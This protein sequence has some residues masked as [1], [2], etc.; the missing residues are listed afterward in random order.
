MTRCLVRTS[1]TKL[2]RQQVQYS[3]LWSHASALQAP[4]HSMQTCLLEGNTPKSDCIRH[5]VPRF[6]A[7]PLSKPTYA[8][9]K[10]PVSTSGA[11]RACASHIGISKQN[12][13]HCNNF[14]CSRYGQGA[15]Q[16][17]KVLTILSKAKGACTIPGILCNHRHCYWRLISYIIL[18]T[19]KFSLYQILAPLV[20]RPM[21]FWRYVN[22]MGLLSCA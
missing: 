1:A 7:M 18:P 19:P 11:D 4:V 13:L 9:E 6:D 22:V 10:R 15:G 16:F 2:T 21:T 8:S 17:K 3:F 14:V 12:Q 5:T 20:R